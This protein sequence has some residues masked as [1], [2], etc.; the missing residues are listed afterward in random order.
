MNAS[1]SLLLDEIGARDA[2]VFDYRDDVDETP[3][4]VSCVQELVDRLFRG[5]L[6]DQ[7]LFG[8]GGDLQ[9]LLFDVDH[10][11]SGIH[12]PYPRADHS[13]EDAGEVILLKQLAA[14]QQRV[15]RILISV[16]V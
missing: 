3:F 6:T 11:H 16:P 5:M 2:K 10:D 8:I 4:D 9:I 12:V 1:I 13:C 15:F 7:A 14:L